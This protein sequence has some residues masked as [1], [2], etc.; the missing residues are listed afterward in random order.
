MSKM[1]KLIIVSTMLFFLSENSF[2]KIWR[3]NNM[4]GVTADFT[5]AQAAHDGASAGDTIHLE[6]SVNSYGSVN[7]NKP[8][9]WL[10]IGSFL[11]DNPGNQ[12][13]TTTGKIESIT[14][15]NGSAG[16]VISLFTNGSVN[17]YTSN[18]TMNRSHIMGTVYVYYNPSNIVITQNFINTYCTIDATN[19][20]F[21]NNIVGYGITM[22]GYNASA[23]ITNNVFNYINRNDNY[24]GPASIYNAVFQNNISIKGGTYTFYNSLPTYNMFP[25]ANFPS[26][27]NN[28]LNVNMSNVFVNHTGTID[29]D[30]QLKTGSPAIAS[31]Y[32][33]IDMG[34]FGGST[35]YKLAM[36]PAIPA[37]TNMSTPSSTGGNTIQVTFSAES[38][39]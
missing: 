23:I 28:L 7:A 22:S 9:V 24:H 38:N 20:I 34:A 35:P 18:I 8:L 6:P 32:G 37:I 25:D 21:S 29:K 5:T 15:S 31:G 36:Q 26:G 17:I 2:A 4:N 13:S 14:F 11:I 10:S 3:V 12:F 30:F 19:V 27:N 1:K 33:S 39:N 16:S